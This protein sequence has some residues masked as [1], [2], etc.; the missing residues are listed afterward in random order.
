MT[1]PTS[2]RSTASETVPDAIRVSPS[3]QALITVGALSAARL[4]NGTEMATMMRPAQAMAIVTALETDE[5]LDGVSPIAKRRTKAGPANRTRYQF[6]SAGWASSPPRR[7]PMPLDDYASAARSSREGRTPI[8]SS[9]L[10]VT[11]FGLLVRSA[12][13]GSGVGLPVS[14]TSRRGAQNVP[15]GARGRARGGTPALHSHGDLWRFR[16]RVHL[17]RSHVGLVVDGPDC[18]TGCWRLDAVEA[19]L[20]TANDTGQVP[21]L[22]AALDHR[23]D[24]GPVG[25]SLLFGPGDDLSESPLAPPNVGVQAGDFGRT[26]IWHRSRAFA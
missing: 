7:R 1:T 5:P 12:P 24:S 4:W 6:V 16:R 8:D 17:W 22:M 26:W 20:V 19:V 15:A 9:V 25:D 11:E 14:S 23:V 21:G 18:G 10:V 3:R 13:D 2:A